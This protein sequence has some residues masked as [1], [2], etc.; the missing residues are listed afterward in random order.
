MDVKILKKWPKFF[1]KNGLLSFLPL[2][3]VE[4]FLQIFHELP[5]P[6]TFIIYPPGHHPPRPTK[7]APLPWA[8]PTHHSSTHRPAAAVADVVGRA[9]GLGAAR[10]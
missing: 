2:N 8:L 10:R 9:L 1:L 7:V 6:Y 4:N 5:L 3:K